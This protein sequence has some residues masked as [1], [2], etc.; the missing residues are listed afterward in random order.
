MRLWRCA[1]VL[2]VLAG[3]SGSNS[4]S[5]SNS[6]VQAQSGFSN[7]NVNG[8]YGWQFSGRIGAAGTLTASVLGTGTLVANGGVLNGGFSET[9]VNLTSNAITVCSGNISGTGPCAFAPTANF[10]LV[11]GNQGH[12][13]VFTS[14]DGNNSLDMSA[15]SM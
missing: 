11:I 9:T 6:T 4:T 15:G 3:C 2:I 5:V 8:S 7:A 12:T 1:A 13:L 10:N 14:T